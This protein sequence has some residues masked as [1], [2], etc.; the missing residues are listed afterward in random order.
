MSVAQQRAQTAA[1]IGSQAFEQN[2]F[3]RGMKHGFEMVHLIEQLADLCGIQGTYG[4]FCDIGHCS[5]RAIICQWLCCGGHCFSMGRIA[6]QPLN[7]CLDT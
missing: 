1:T 3:L 2:V 5:V 4:D 6:N 7:A